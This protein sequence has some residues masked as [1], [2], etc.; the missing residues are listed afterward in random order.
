VLKYAALHYIADRF[1]VEAKALTPSDARRVLSEATFQDPQAL[2]LCSIFERYFNADFAGS[3][4][5]AST[6]ARDAATAIEIIGHVEKILREMRVSRQ[7]D[8]HPRGSAVLSAI[9]LAALALAEFSSAADTT[10]TL[11]NRFMWNAAQARTIASRSQDE[12]AAA[13]QSYDSLLESGMHN[14]A[15]FYNYGVTLLLSGQPAKAFRAFLRAER[16]LG[17]NWCIRRNMRIA[18]AGESRD[19]YPSLPWHRIPLFWHYGLRA[20][21]RM[22][23]ACFASLG[24]WVALL[25]RLGGFVHSYRRLMAISVA[26]L[27]L[28]GSSV[29]T[30]IQQESK[31]DALSRIPTCAPPASDATPTPEGG[32]G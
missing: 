8:H 26:L 5:S 14:G 11:R 19:V 12:F 29:L 24:I 7:K 17:V 22:T 4:E 28:F 1:S 13:A 21:T 18:V 6:M 31:A 27:I 16:Y 15:L 9:L 10:E 32:G 3:V 23:T 20:E 25:L 2:E 30:T